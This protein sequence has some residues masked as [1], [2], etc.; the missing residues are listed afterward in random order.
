MRGE[1][2]PH[3]AWTMIFVVS[4]ILLALPVASLYYHAED[5]KAT[6]AQITHLVQVERTLALQYG[7]GTRFDPVEVFDEAKRRAFARQGPHFDDDLS[8]VN[9]LHTLRKRRSYLRSMGFLQIIYPFSS[10]KC[11]SLYLSRDKTLSYSLLS[12][13]GEI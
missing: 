10:R 9:R 12:S 1:N 11:K 4:A 8:A 7:M 6:E 2:S 5:I 13:F 3:S